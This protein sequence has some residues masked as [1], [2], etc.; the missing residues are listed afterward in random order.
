MLNID[1]EIDARAAEKLKTAN[2]ARARKAAE[3]RAE[4][5][6]A[7]AVRA[8]RDADFQRERELRDR[9]RAAQK[10]RDE[11]GSRAEQA[12]A[13]VAAAQQAF[14]QAKRKAASFDSLRIVRGEE[15]AA[16]IAAAVD[17]GMETDL[18][19]SAEI[20]AKKAE[21]REAHMAMLE[22]KEQL[23]DIEAAEGILNGKLAAIDAEVDKAGTEVRRIANEIVSILAARHARAIAEEYLAVGRGSKYLRPKR[24]SRM[25]HS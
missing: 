15:A 20:E 18:T 5:E 19:M 13:R 9:L 2:E 10:V 12:R 4:E 1:Q 25:S 11:A 22:A 21:A 17:A 6:R 23:E 7:M 3:K 24:T 16:K 8:A 14:E